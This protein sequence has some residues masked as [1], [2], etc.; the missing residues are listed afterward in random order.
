MTCTF[1]GRVFASVLDT[2]TF[3]LA[4]STDLFCF[5]IV[6]SAYLSWFCLS[7]RVVIYLTPASVAHTDS[8]V[9]MVVVVMSLPLLLF[10]LSVEELAVS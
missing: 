8:E 5:L 9:L 7:W 3:K 6:P 2:P 1:Q 4:E 10:T